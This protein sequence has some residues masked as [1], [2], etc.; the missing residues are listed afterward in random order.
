[1]FSSNICNISF[2]LV[3]SASEKT[4][5]VIWL[6]PM[7]SILKFSLQ[8]IK[9]KREKKIQSFSS[10][11]I[12]HNHENLDIQRCHKRLFLFLLLFYFKEFVTLFSNYNPY[13][14]TVTEIYHKECIFSVEERLEYNKNRTCN[15]EY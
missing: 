5:H 2:V 7:F 1:M 3:E 10:L 14:I 8:L 15:P 6:T 13:H 12:I 4:H 9:L 11:R